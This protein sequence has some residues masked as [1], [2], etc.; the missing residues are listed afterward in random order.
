MN[1]EENEKSD[2]NSINVSQKGSL[3]IFY[4]FNFEHASAVCVCVWERE[5]NYRQLFSL[6]FNQ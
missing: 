3:A 1:K 6:H 4:Y 5:N 2:T